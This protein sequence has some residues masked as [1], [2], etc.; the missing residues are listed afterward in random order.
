MYVCMHVYIHISNSKAL[1]GTFSHI[2]AYVHT[3]PGAFSHMHI[4]IAALSGTYFTHTHTYIHAYI[5]TYS[6]TTH[7][8][9]QSSV[10]FEHESHLSTKRQA[11][12]I[13]FLS[14]PPLCMY[15]CIFVRVSMYVCMTP[16]LSAPFPV[17]VCLYIFVRVYVFM[18]CNTHA[19]RTHVCVF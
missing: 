12:E 7:S 10:Y 13:P 17:D 15:V 8:A 19:Y 5:H 2:H 4:H 6:S 16:S 9:R 11:Q 3:L 14:A 18:F 1:L